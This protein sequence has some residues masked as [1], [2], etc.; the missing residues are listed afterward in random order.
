MNADDRSTPPITGLCTCG[1]TAGP[2]TCDAC[3]P[4]CDC[5]PCDGG[6]VLRCA[7]DCNCER[8][9]SEDPPE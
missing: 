6:W 4:G 5:T 9:Q 2:C 3:G 8:C 7:A 1:E